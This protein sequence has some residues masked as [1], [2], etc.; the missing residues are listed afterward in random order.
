MHSK[1]QKNKAVTYRKKTY[2]FQSGSNGVPIVNKFFAK[3]DVESIVTGVFLGVGSCQALMEMLNNVMGHCFHFH[4]RSNQLQPGKEDKKRLFR[5]IEKD[6]NDTELDD[7]D[8]E[9]ESIDAEINSQE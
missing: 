7:V 3:D 2:V 4:P 9:L 8:K 5:D 1:N 6:L